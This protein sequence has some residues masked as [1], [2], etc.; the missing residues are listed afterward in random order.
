MQTLNHNLSDSHGTRLV[1]AFCGLH[2]YDI[3]AEEGETRKQ[4][5]K[6]L[7][8]EWLVRQVRRWEQAEANRLADAALTEIDVTSVE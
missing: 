2:Q 4:F 7:I 6:R 1:D 8:R 5:A 3:N